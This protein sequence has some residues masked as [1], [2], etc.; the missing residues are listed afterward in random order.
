MLEFHLKKYYRLEKM[1]HAKFHKKLSFNKLIIL[2][3]LA[4]DDYQTA[5]R[6]HENLSDK[7]H[8]DGISLIKIHDE[9]TFRD[10]IQA[11]K[12]L[13]DPELNLGFKPIIH[14]EAHGTPLALELPD[15][16]MI[17]WSDLAEDFRIINKV[18]RNELI[19]FIGTCHGYHFIF[20]NHTIKEFAPVYFCIAPL[21]K[22]AGGDIECSALSFYESLFS[23]GDLTHSA[24]LLDSSIFYIYNSDYM[25]HRAFYETMQKQ[26]RGEALRLRKETLISEA[27]NLMGDVWK[28]MSPKEKKAYLRKARVLLNHSLKS[29]EALRVEFER[30]S[31]GYMGYVNEE[32][33]EEIWNHMQQNKQGSIY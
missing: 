25:F 26:H 6:L 15:K 32:V 7:G 29:R 11:I 17:P 13:F 8:G 12:D 2:D 22:I 9:N 1:Q 14:I 3:C 31:M 23:T 28:T 4:E 21:E 27:I 24:N 18:M 19:T 5:R 33:F 16:S 20:N 10:T 30:F